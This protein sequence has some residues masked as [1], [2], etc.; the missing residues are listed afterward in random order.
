VIAAGETGVVVYELSSF[1]LWDLK[2]SPHVAVVLMIE[3]EHLDVHRDFDEYKEAKRNIVAFQTK[4]DVVVYYADN[5][6]TAAIAQSSA[7]HKLPY[8]VAQ[9]NVLS[10]DGK[11]IVARA[12]IQ[13]YGEHNIGNVQAALIAAWQYTHDTRAM[14]EAVREFRGLPHRLE[15][16]G[17]V[18]GVLYINDSF[19]SAP[20]ATL[21]AVKAFAQPKIVIMGGYD[22]GLDFSEIAR[23]IAQQPRLKKV[24]LMGVARHRIADAFNACGCK[25]YEIIDG[26]MEYAVARAA[27]IAVTGDVVLLSPG[28]ASFDMFRDFSQRGDMFRQLVAAL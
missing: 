21:A 16:V 12:D 22:R 23:A 2:K 9:G 4:D 13:L 11:S 15:E 28:C 19:S 20:P 7:A 8:G 27:E 24:L 1:Q 6:T 14:A 26:T 5:E 25:D 10:V 3:P 18:R 17:V